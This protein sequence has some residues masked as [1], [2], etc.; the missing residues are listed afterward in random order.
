MKIGAPD[1][2]SKSKQ[3]NVPTTIDG[4]AFW[5]FQPVKDYPVPAAND[6]AWAVNPIDNFI[7]AKL[8]GKGLEHAPRADKRTLIRRAY[9]DL[10]GLPPTPEQVDRFVQDNDPKGYER[11]IDELLASEHYGER[12]G[13]HSRRARYADSGGYETDIYFRNAWRYRDGVVKSLMTTS[14]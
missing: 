4:S 8:E 12:W 14:P 9:F 1:P 2:R 13:R 5:S 10:I 11:L 3:A 7:L 6:P